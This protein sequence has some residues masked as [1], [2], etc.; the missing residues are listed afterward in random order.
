MTELDECCRNLFDWFM[1]IMIIIVLTIIYITP[2]LQ[3]HQGLNSH[4]ESQ[5]YIQYIHTYIYICIHFSTCMHNKKSNFSPI[6]GFKI[7]IVIK[8]KLL[9]FQNYFLL[10]YFITVITTFS[11]PNKCPCNY[12]ILR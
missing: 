12:S 8:E 7:I 6:T 9:S 11:F 2:K 3:T 1:T 5:A 4:K 10:S